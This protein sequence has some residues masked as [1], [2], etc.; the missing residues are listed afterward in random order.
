MR[1]LN[2]LER[3]MLIQFHV[4]RGLTFKEA[5]QRVNRDKDQIKSLNRLKGK[6]K[7][8]KISKVDFLDG[9]YHP[10]NRKRR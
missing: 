4:R 2:Y 3:K 9:L 8:K 10:T 6:K 1:N 5:C 7:D